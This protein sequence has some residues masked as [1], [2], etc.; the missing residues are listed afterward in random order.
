[1]DTVATIRMLYAEGCSLPEMI[2]ATGK[3]WHYVRSCL[4]NCQRPARRCW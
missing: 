3:D 4:V 1:M 2:S